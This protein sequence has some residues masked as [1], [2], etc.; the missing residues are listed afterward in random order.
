MARPSFTDGPPDRC[1]PRPKRPAPRPLLRHRR[2]LRG[3]GLESGVLPIPDEKIVR[4]ASATRQDVPDRHGAGPHHRRQE[5]VRTVAAAKPLPGWIS[6]ISIRLT[7]VPGPRRC[8]P[9]C[10]VAAGSSSSPF[11]TFDIKCIV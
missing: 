8:G 6:R 2:R 9:R 11:H 7:P 5:I 10:N 4:R 3:H 1:H